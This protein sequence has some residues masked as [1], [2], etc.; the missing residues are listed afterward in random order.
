MVEPATHI[1]RLGVDVYELLPI[2]RLQDKADK[3]RAFE[4]SDKYQTSLAHNKALQSGTLPKAA[5][6]DESGHYIH[7]RDC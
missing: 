7:S 3:P 1:R 6:P 2:S 4:S 5:E